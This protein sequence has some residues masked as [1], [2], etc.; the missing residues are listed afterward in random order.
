MFNFI[1]AS[2][3]LSFDF[4]AGYIPVSTTAEFQAPAHFL[5]SRGKSF[6]TTL[7]PTIEVSGFYIDF[8]YSYYASKSSGKIQFAPYK[9]IWTNTIG[10]G[11]KNFGIGWSH[12]CAH[13]INP[14]IFNPYIL[15]QRDDTID[16]IFIN[17]S[18][19]AG[20]NK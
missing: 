15:E 10:Y 7:N 5:C 11:Y 2:L 12:T 18:F 3:L 17:I 6:Y 16:K 14:V 1:M 9:G 19:S 13:S 4:E 8:E 20:A